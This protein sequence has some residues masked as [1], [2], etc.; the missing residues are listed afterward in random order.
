MKSP[1][2][3]GLGTIDQLSADTCASK[4]VARGEN[5]GSEAAARRAWRISAAVI[6]GLVL[7]IAG[8]GFVFWTSFLL[9][10][11]AKLVSR[12]LSLTRQKVGL[13]LGLAKME[14]ARGRLAHALRFAAHSVQLASAGRQMPELVEEA[15][16]QLSKIM[17]DTQWILMFAGHTGG[18][19][20]AAF[21]NDGARIITVSGENTAQV[22]DT[23][24]GEPLLV[25][26]GHDAF[27]SSASFNPDGSRV[28]TASNDKTARVWD[29][30][31]GKELIVLR[32][33]EGPVLT[34]AFSSDGSRIVTGSEDMT[35]RVWDASSG[36]ELL[37]VRGEKGADYPWV[38]SGMRERGL[39]PV[40]HLGRIV[41]AIFSPDGSQILAVSGGTAVMWDAETGK[42]VWA[43]N[44][45][46]VNSATFSRDGSRV[47]AALKDKSVRIWDAITGEELL[48]M[49]G[50][51]GQVYSAVFSP[52]GSRIV[53]ASQDETARIWDA[54]TGKQLLA[55][56]GH[57]GELHSAAFS[58]DGMRVV[59]AS[60]D[61]TARIWESTGKE[62]RAL[63][64]GE[65]DQPV[66]SASFSPDGLRVLR[67]HRT[68]SA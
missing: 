5:S 19:R 37:R 33:H 11:Q 8:V 68:M 60:E 43:L 12:E 67:K 27:V 40:G 49:S 54:T 24:T 28:I 26:R 44:Y 66:S 64:S 30:V 20:Q 55:L 14:E 17:Y 35:A 39:E 65:D 63:R 41:A 2:T 10:K 46:R 31:T 25:L 1:Y 16:D 3:S 51:H 32:G 58:P 38:R 9:E 61:K 22:W 59:T 4:H 62:L 52:E 23:K 57:E 45:V 29:G 13:T 15:H 7:V 42:E 48:V 34:A 6:A 21:R 18:V 53:T 50:H 56:R 47:V 36:K